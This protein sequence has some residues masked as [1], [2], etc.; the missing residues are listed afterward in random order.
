MDHADYLM[1]RIPRPTLVL[2]CH[3]A[4]S[5]TST[6]PG[7]RFREAKKVFGVAGY[8]ERVEIFEYDTTHGYPKQQREAMLRFFRRW[9]ML[10]DDPVYED[11]F[12][13]IEGAELQCTRTGQVVEDLK[14][15]TVFAITAERADELEPARAKLRT[16]PEELT[17]EVRRLLGVSSNI[18]VPEYREVGDVKRD[19]CFLVKVLFETEPGI[20]VP[21][22]LFSPRKEGPTP[23]IIY[24]NAMGKDKDAGVNGRCEELAK[25]GNRVLA[26]DLR[27]FGETAPAPAS[28]K[29]GYFGNTYRESFLSLHLNRPLLGQR[30]HDLL[31][32]TGFIDQKIGKHVSAIE[33]IGSGGCG[34]VALHAAALIRASRR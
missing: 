19:D 23:L 27:G 33:V 24:L 17:A 2:C 13:T 32:V 3:A 22:L 6:A 12:A 21:G 25:A 26:L 16:Q 29:P 30:V 14:G 15:K 4:T 34:L 8:G 7:R 9:L 5:S 1:M 31:A 11:E 28:A 20:I 18:P 10:K